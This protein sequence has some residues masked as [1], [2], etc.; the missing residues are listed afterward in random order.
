MRSDAS[1]RNAEKNT[2]VLGNSSV[3]RRSFAFARV[4]IFFR[5]RRSELSETRADPHGYPLTGHHTPTAPDACS[6]CPHA[7]ARAGCLH[8]QRR[9]SRIALRHA[10]WPLR[11]R[12]PSFGRVPR[13]LGGPGERPGS[14]ELA[15]A[16]RPAA[17]AR[18]QPRRIGARAAR[19]PLGAPRGRLDRLR[20]PAEKKTS[21]CGCQHARRPERRAP[22]AAGGVSGAVHR[23][24]QTGRRRHGRR[25]RPWRR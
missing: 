22:R 1:S 19:V 3:S 16:R 2:S 23:D 25:D 15:H 13:T 7:R 17:A 21:L 10:N 12:V 5:M 18:D 14:T 4:A 6:T 24:A 9:A 11:A 20:D 8:D